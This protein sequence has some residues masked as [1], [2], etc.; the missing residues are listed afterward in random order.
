MSVCVGA[1]GAFWCKASS[2]PPLAQ[3]PQCPPPPHRHCTEKMAIMENSIAFSSAPRREVDSQPISQLDRPAVSQTETHTLGFLSVADTSSSS[4]EHNG[5]QDWQWP[6]GNAG[7]CR[8]FGWRFEP[9]CGRYC[10]GAAAGVCP[11]G[12]EPSTSQRI[13][14][15]QHTPKIGWK[16]HKYGLKH[17]LHTSDD[18]FR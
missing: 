7:D 13:Y 5:C 11:P 8:H 16:L 12:F 4:W 17:A 18:H 1:S 10:S 9:R 2:E 15:E 3:T 6:N 14:A